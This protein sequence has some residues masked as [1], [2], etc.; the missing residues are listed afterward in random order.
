MI[1]SVIMS[2]ITVGS[3]KGGTGKSTL[4]SNLSVLLSTNG[5]ET[6]LVD[7]DRNNSVSLWSRMR[8]ENAV[9]PRIPTVLLLDKTPLY[10]L[11][12]LSKKYQH[13][14][15]D[16]A[17]HDSIEFRSS[18]IRSDIFLLVLKPSQFDVWSLEH[19]APILED[20]T[21]LHNPKLKTYVVLNQ[22][23][24]HY[25][26]DLPSKAKSVLEDYKDVS[27]CNSVIRHRKAFQ[28]CVESGLSVLETGDRKASTEMTNLYEELYA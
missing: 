12:E 27:I 17:G 21:E 24:T 11:P 9:K 16:S 6:M 26:D 8:G 1:T 28:T 18:L 19:L 15:V 4:S 13:I 22:A 10:E 2:I 20:V 7:T 23:S 3:T 14:V 5:Y 25:A